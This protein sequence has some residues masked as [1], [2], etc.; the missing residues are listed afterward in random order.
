MR[1]LFLILFML[2]LDL[3]AWQAIR[4]LTTSWT[5]AWKLTLQ[6]VYWS[7]SLLAIGFVLASFLLPN[8]SLSKSVL[9]FFRAFIFI[10]YLSKFVVSVFLLIDDLRRLFAWGYGQVAGSTPFDPGRAR[11]LS[12]TGLLM[13]GIPLATLSY[14]ILRNPYRYKTFGAEAEIEDLPEALDGLKVVQISD[15]H[16][17]SFF[18][19]EPV[20]RAVDLINA[21]EP[22]LVFFT[23]DMVN[24]QASEMEPYMDVFD[25][26]ESRYGVFSVRGNH[27]YGD[28]H[29]WPSAEAKAANKDR[30]E[31]IQR[32]MGWQLLSNENRLL[33]IRG[34]QVAVIG[35]E[36]MSALSRFPKYGDLGKAQEGTE[37]AAVRLLLSHDPSYWDT[38]CEEFPDIDLTFSGHT[39]GFQF[40]IEIPGFLRWSPSQY[41]YRQW[42]GLYSRG[43]QHLYVNRGLGFLGYPGRVGILP[44]VTAMTLRKKKSV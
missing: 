23:G 35:I 3:Y 6:G 12:T 5:P 42:A 24:S 30:F 26:I 36:N 43:K 29:R 31:E 22:D 13:G 4:H 25:K 38:I 2:G 40:G 9:T 44:E 8:F 41:M 21:E 10:I 20:R 15:I 16:S 18:F 33:D 28:Y 19:K 32:E 39:H 11:F 27:D 7:I 37:E 34:E 17:G 1:L 14:G